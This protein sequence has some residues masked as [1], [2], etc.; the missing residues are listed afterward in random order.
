[1]KKGLI[2]IAALWMVA[3]CSDAPPL[4]TSLLHVH[5]TPE[6]SGLVFPDQGRFENNRTVQVRAVPASSYEFVRWEG[7]FS[8]TEPTYEWLVLA[9]AEVTAVF[10]LREDIEK[11]PD[12]TEGGATD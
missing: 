2:L 8:G 9:E 11:R 12:S 5:V 10:A 3:A 1:M 4:A 6:G 7:D